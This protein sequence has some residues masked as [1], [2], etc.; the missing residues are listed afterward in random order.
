MTSFPFLSM[1]NST[2]ENLPHTSIVTRLLSYHGSHSQTIAGLTCIGVSFVIVVS[3]YA[4]NA[5]EA[6]SIAVSAICFFIDLFYHGFCFFKQIFINFRLN[7]AHF[8]ETE[9]LF[10][11]FLHANHV[12]CPVHRMLQKAL[13]LRVYRR[14]VIL[15]RQHCY[16]NTVLNTIEP[17]FVQLFTH[18]SSNTTENTRHPFSFFRNTL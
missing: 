7:I 14:W 4:V 6:V 13:V 1:S 3:V 11:V 12:N 5:S 9:V 10:V 17:K 18:Y 2:V 15:F 16:R 8:V